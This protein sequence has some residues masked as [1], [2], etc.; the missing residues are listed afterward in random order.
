MK[1]SMKKSMLIAVLAFGLAQ[2]SAQGVG[3]DRYMTHYLAVKDALVQGDAA[4][5]QESGALLKA[6]LHVTEDL[7]GP[8]QKVYSQQFDALMAGAHSIA[9]TRDI[10]KQRQAFAKLSPA[11]W[12]L[13]KTSAGLNGN[14]YYQYCPMRKAY[15]ISRTKAIENPYYGASML[16]CGSVKEIH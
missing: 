4:S 2:L 7:G 10:E 5:A 12:E 16:T 1:Y 13:V 11:L 15:W 8:E 6:A 3:V 14:Y 9:D